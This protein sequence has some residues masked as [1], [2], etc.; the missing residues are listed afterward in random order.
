MWIMSCVFLESVYCSTFKILVSFSYWCYNYR[1]FLFFWSFYLWTAVT[2]ICPKVRTSWNVE[3]TI[4]SSQF[5]I[6]YVRSFTLCLLNVDSSVHL[7]MS[8]RVNDFLYF[9]FLL[10]LGIHSQ[11]WLVKRLWT[12]SHMDSYAFVLNDRPYNRCN[13]RS[14]ILIP[15]CWERNESPSD[16]RFIQ[17][18][19]LGESRPVSLFGMVWRTARRIARSVRT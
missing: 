19:I 11:G 13:L 6:P 1:L 16:R 2:R 8:Q 7:F 18:V 14:V 12:T 4:D 9:S 5:Y 15:Y 3:W 17:D 10:S